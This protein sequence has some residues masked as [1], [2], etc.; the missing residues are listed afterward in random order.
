MEKLTNN[1]KVRYNRQML[2]EGWGEE[3]QTKLKNSSVF[4][5]GAGGLGSTVSTYLAIAGVGEIKICDADTIELSDLNRQI[6]HRDVRIGELKAVSAEKALKELNPNIN[7]VNYSDYITEDNAEQIVGTPDIVVD[8]LDN[9]KT[10]YLLNNYCLKHRI[11]FVHG[12]VH[13]MIG[14]VTFLSPPETP[15]LRCIFPEAP[16]REIVPVVAATPGLIGCIQAIEVLKYLTE[17][18]TLL[19]GRLLVIDGQDMVFTP[20]K[21]ERTQACP[22][23]GSSR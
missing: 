6:L 10:R 5:A 23:C 9:F 7:V 15:C 8:C 17:V 4:I 19:K 3:G 20:I 11:P 12:G 1:E 2:I 22:D 13:A 16:S 14:Q 18:G 21:I